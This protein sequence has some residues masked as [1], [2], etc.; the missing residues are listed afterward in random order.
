MRIIETNLRDKRIVVA[1]I[2]SLRSQPIDD[3]QRRTLANVVDILLVRNAEQVNPGA[4]DALFRGVERVAEEAP[5][6]RRRPV[7]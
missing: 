6:G 2:R 4:V 1:N 7:A 3:R 5:R